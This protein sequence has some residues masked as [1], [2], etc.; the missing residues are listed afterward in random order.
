MTD[1]YE[2]KMSEILNHSTNKQTIEETKA[3]ECSE[4]TLSIKCTSSKLKMEPESNGEK[5]CVFK[6]MVI[7]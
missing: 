5:K 2:K 3:G 4:N 1:N 7:L 6:Q